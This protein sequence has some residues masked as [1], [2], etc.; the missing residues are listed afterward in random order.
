MLVVIDGLDASGKDTQ[1]G[2][3]SDLLRKRGMTFI[4]RS[5][6]SGDNSFGRRARDYLMLEGRRAH[7][8]ASIFYLADVYRS[9]LLYSWRRVDCV[10]FVR[11]LLGTAYLPRPLHRVAYLFF[12]HIVPRAR[13]MVFIDV[14][15][16]EAYRRVSANRVTRERFETLEELE[17]TGRKAGD[18]VSMGGWVVVDGTRSPD[19]IHLAILKAIGLSPGA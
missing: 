11:Y 2:L 1:A 3:L 12:S 16:A 5:H 6:P 15:P 17:K 18:I 14:P 9:I 8:A 7:F 13:G 10:V 19:Q 4:V